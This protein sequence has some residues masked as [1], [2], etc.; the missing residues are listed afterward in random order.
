[1]RLLAAVLAL[2]GLVLAGGGGAALVAD[3]DA[4]SAGIT[5]LEL[6]KRLMFAA[7]AARLQPWNAAYRGDYAELLG[8][9][10]EDAVAA[11]VRGQFQS[12]LQLG[13]GDAGIWLRWEGFIARTTPEEPALPAAAQ[14]VDQLAPYEPELQFGQAELALQSWQQASP[15]AQAVW[16]GSLRYAL[17]RDRAG[18]LLHSFRA[19]EETN[20]CESAPALGLQDWCRL[21]QQTRI[22][23]ARGGLNPTQNQFCRLM[24]SVNAADSADLP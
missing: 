21:A 2:F 24:G 14:R 6:K 17:R 19:A 20:L 5:Q 1:M 18:F 15:A 13:S 8:A 23:C 3:A 22:G 11:S 12:A 16:M 10:G 9:G 4:Q 7:A